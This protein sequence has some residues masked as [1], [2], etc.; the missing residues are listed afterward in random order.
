MF[1]QRKKN[2]RLVANTVTD[3]I[4]EGKSI[5]IRIMDFVMSNVDVETITNS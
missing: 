3:M 5:D 1:S 4:C 2:T